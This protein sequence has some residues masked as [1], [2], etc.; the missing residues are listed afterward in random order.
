M[1]DLIILRLVLNTSFPGVSLGNLESQEGRGP[2][3]QKQAQTKKK[4]KKKKV[5][6]FKTIIIYASVN[7]EI[8]S[9]PFPGECGYFLWQVLY[10]PN[11]FLHTKII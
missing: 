11:L 5:C 7:P 9:E 3:T 1:Y 6:I 2:N 8:T 4:K 10:R